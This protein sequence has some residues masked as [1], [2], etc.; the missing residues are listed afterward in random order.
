MC[1]C[2]AAN[3]T[4]KQ[5]AN[6][7]GWRSPGPFF[8]FP[9]PQKIP[10]KPFAALKDAAYRVHLPVF[11][12][13]EFFPPGPEILV[14]PA[15]RM[16]VFVPFRAVFAWC[17]HSSL[18]CFCFRRWALVM[19]F[20]AHLIHA[21]WCKICACA[22]ACPGRRKLSLSDAC[23][24]IS[25][26]SS[27]SSGAKMS[28][29]VLILHSIVFW[30]HISTTVRA[31]GKARLHSRHQTAAV[32]TVPPVHAASKPRPVMY[33]AP[34]HHLANIGCGDFKILRFYAIFAYR[35]S[36]NQSRT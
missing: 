34:M 13:I 18:L 15:A 1:R 12:G 35:L 30:P 11:F 4:F 14:F 31:E 25:A 22:A 29:I 6:S 27:P 28:S 32:A 2:Q 33:K 21:C 10:V 20:F 24:H 19:Y 17:V 5:Q 23:G 9:A 16:A 8:L 26:S 7:P 36:N 3:T